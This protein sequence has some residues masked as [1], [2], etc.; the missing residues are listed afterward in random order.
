MNKDGSLVI[1]LFW[2]TSLSIP[3]WVSLIGWVWLIADM[4]K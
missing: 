1:G 2:S 4:M 3:L